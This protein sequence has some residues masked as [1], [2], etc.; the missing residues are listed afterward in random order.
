[1]SPNGTA[2]AASTHRRVRLVGA[3]KFK[4]QCLP[5]PRAEEW[6]W[7]SHGRCRDYPAAVFFPEQ[8]RGERL[9]RT[10]A[11]A[12]RICQECPV[13]AECRKYALSVPEIYG[14]WGGLDETER[15]QVLAS[16]GSRRQLSAAAGNSTFGVNPRE[17]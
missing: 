1:M 4:P 9:R 14:I 5:A 2:G 17:A 16:A 10:E 8:Q 3:S 7:Q 11:A 6:T 12:K 15:A 13:I